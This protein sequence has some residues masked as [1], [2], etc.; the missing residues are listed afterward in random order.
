MS[1]NLAAILEDV[2]ALAPAIYQSVM[3]IKSESNTATKVQMAT[4]ALNAATGISTAVLS[5]DPTLQVQATA[6]SQAASA[7]MYAVHVSSSTTSPV[8]G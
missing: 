4:D 2:L 7:I 6:A 5:N 1:F 8:V 3:G